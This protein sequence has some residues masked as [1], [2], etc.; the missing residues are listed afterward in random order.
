[1][2]LSKITCLS[3]LAFSAGNVL[4]VNGDNVKNI[5]KKK[6]L[7][8]IWT[9][10]QRAS[11]MAV[12]GN[13]EFKVPTMNKLA[14]EST[15]FL[16]NYVAQPVCTPSRG[17]VMT[18]LYPHQHCA[19]ANN[20]PLCKEAKTLPE[21]LNDPSYVTGYFGKWHLGDEIFAQHGFQEFESTEDV[22]SP[23]F[24]AGRDKEARSGY[25]H[26]LISHGMKPDQPE[27][28]SF[29]RKF[30]VSL[31]YEFTKPAYLANKAVDFLERHKN[32]H[33]VLYINY[34]EPH[35]PFDGPFNNLHNG[36]ALTL[37]PNFMVPLTNDDPEKYH[38]SAEPDKTEAEWRN[39]YQHYAGLCA[40]VDKSMEKILA[41][42]KELGLED[43]T[44]IVFTSD[45]GEMM[46]SHQQAFKSK[47]YQEA[48]K[49]PL[50]IRNPDNKGKQFI[51]KDPVGSID[52]VPTLLD[53]MGVKPAVKLPGRSLA[54]AVN[55]KKMT[56]EPAFS[57]WSS[58]VK[59]S[60]DGEDAGG[61]NFRTVLS[62]D[63]WKLTL[64]DK[65]K[66]Q[67]FNLNIDPF[68]LN[69]LYYKPVSRKTIERLARQIKEWQTSI[70]DNLSLTL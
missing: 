64:S 38:R 7:L 42:L 27:K 5:P 57:I 66:N 37:P 21:L 15:V 6:N 45:H 65:D 46:G 34:L 62:P 68:E 4:A 33:F 36:N 49:V 59:G 17:T 12:Y 14:S 50:L 3:L 26:F 32:E 63:G 9:D 40:S 69:N 28:N 53:L 55:G 67:L 35:T 47:M 43:N 48:L 44:I 24:S 29:S 10:Q 60:E 23:H 61:P 30:A 22:Y 31:P 16:N 13:K 58:V 19:Q 52:I 41:K 20:M 8:F 2:N 51:V 54:R 39:D 18:G 1:M 11:T 70:G 56:P 25:F